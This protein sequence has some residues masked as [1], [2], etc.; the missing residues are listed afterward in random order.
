MEEDPIPTSINIISTTVPSFRLKENICHRDCLIIL[1]Q[2]LCICVRPMPPQWIWA[3][4]SD[5][6]S[7]GKSPCSGWSSG[8]LG[9]MD[10]RLV[11]VRCC[12]WI[13]K[14]DSKR[15]GS[16]LFQIQ[17][18]FSQVSFKTPCLGSGWCPNSVTERKENSKQLKSSQKITPLRA[19]KGNHF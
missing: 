15:E 3:E 10:T 14:S 17:A 19:D 13:L 18:C 8:R 11:N 1:H 4:D 6:A 16:P 5:V 7:R 12:L 9:V 2:T